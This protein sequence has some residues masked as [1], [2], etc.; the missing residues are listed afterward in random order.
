MEQRGQVRGL[1]RDT[2]VP[3]PDFG[4]AIRQEGRVRADADRVEQLDEN[5]IAEIE[6][7]D[8]IDAPQPAPIVNNPA[9]DAVIHS[10]SDSESDDSDV[11]VENVVQPVDLHQHEDS[12]SSEDEMAS[13]LQ[14][15]AY[16]GSYSED[17]VT[18]MQNVSWYILTTKANN[19]RARIAFVSMLLKDEAK[20]WFNS[21]IIALDG[22]QQRQAAVD[23]GQAQAGD[24]AQAR[25]TG[26]RK[27]LR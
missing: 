6:A 16:H 11:E 2:V 26:L 18:W 27:R 3:Q 15:P 1:I 22:A 12:D 9:A 5:F 8:N 7:V 23:G 21:L 19:D 14:P 25:W 20:R 24:G 4:D 10:D 13:S 17:A